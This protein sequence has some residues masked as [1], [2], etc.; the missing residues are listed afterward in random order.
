[1]K[2]VYFKRRKGVL[3]GAV[4]GC[5]L[6][7]AAIM[8]MTGCG[9]RKTATPASA[10]AVERQE[11]ENLRADDASALLHIYRPKSFVGA[12]VSYHIHMGD[13]PLFRVTNNSKTTVRVTRDGLQSLW[14]RTEAKSEIPLEIEFGKEYYIRCGVSM[15]AF[16]GRPA[17][18][19]M[20]NRT[21]KTEFDAVRIK[22]K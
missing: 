14:G 19:L 9:T 5:M 17:F 1:M 7:F 4:M 6:L 2:K 22:K 10:D 16:V 18:T 15:G 3:R 8:L 12:V 13:E 21:G 20:D 11:T